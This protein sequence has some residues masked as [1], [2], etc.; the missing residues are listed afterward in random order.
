ME[1]ELTQGNQKHLTSKSSNQD[2]NQLLSVP[3]SKFSISPDHITADQN[4]RQ[5]TVQDVDASDFVYDK[6]D[7]YSVNADLGAMGGITDVASS[8]SSTSVGWTGEGER[9]KIKRS[10]T[11][12]P[13]TP[14]N[15][16]P[17]LSSNK[18]DSGY[19]SP[20]TF[21]ASLTP[22]HFSF[23][24]PSSPL[25]PD[26][27]K[28][29]TS[30]L[31]SAPARSRAL[32]SPTFGGVQ[33]M[34]FYDDYQEAGLE[35]CEEGDDDAFVSDAPISAPA[36]LDTASALRM[37]L[38]RQKMT[39]PRTRSRY[40]TGDLDDDDLVDER[41]SQLVLRDSDSEDDEEEPAAVTK[42]RV[43]HFSESN[44]DK[45]TIT[46]STNTSFSLLSDIHSGLD[47]HQENISDN[48]AAQMNYDCIQPSR[49]SMH[50][51]L[52]SSNLSS[53]S[54]QHHDLV[55][56]H[57]DQTIAVTDLHRG[58]P[59]AAM[60]PGGE[61]IRPQVARSIA[62]QTPTHHCQIID[63]ILNSP[64]EMPYCARGMLS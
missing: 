6:E 13:R 51:E 15:P 62:T 52:T 34:E 31:A 30:P 22:Q 50:N 43:R 37:E 20:A 25:S 28:F 1:E 40:S 32:K 49:Y 26:V 45:T 57:Y 59:S 36:K 46:V 38:K 63:Q 60:L 2:P 42:L 48:A 4:L 33:V 16:N 27:S 17:T 41:W 11:S 24:D 19:Y 5:P 61:R 44:I 14:T 21:S 12:L 10:S 18:R 56:S 3:P 8:S 58:L 47:S 64:V 9:I 29:P 55:E 35:L 53:P 39:T 7:F 23:D 54:R